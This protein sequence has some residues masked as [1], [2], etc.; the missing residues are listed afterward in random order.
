MDTNQAVCL[1]I[2][3][4]FNIPP[5]LCSLLTRSKMPVRQCHNVVIAREGQTAERETHCTSSFSN[6]TKEAHSQC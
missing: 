5:E 1:E 4:Y 6:W 3:D 2:K